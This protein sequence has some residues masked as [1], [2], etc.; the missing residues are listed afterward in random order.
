[1]PALELL[2]SIRS[3]AGDEYASRIPEATR[4]NIATVGNTIL[5]YSPTLNAFLTELLNRIAKVVVEK[6]ED[7]ED[8]YG[9][10]KDEQLPFGD[11]IQ[12]IYILFI[13]KFHTIIFI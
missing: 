8:I 2:N 4:Q 9:V 13:I 10:F 6:M 3:V 5:A 7:V 1:M 11:A 12:K